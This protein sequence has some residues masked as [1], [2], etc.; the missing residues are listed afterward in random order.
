MEIKAY[1]KAILYLALFIKHF[2]KV[3]LKKKQTILRHSCKSLT[4]VSTFILFVFGLFAVRCLSMLFFVPSAEVVRAM[5]FPEPDS[6]SGFF[7]LKGRCSSSPS[8]SASSLSLALAHIVGSLLY[9]K[10]TNKRLETAV[11]E[12]AMKDK[13]NEIN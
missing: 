10:Y 9:N 13:L 11:V 5:P 2:F 6:G 8:L 7:Q 4:F 12:T 3:P 1:R